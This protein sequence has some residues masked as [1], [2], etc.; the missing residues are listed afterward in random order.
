MPER[1]IV[2]ADTGSGSAFWGKDLNVVAF[3]S[4]WCQKDILEGDTNEVAGCSSPLI[5]QA[6]DFQVAAFNLSIMD[7]D[8]SPIVDIV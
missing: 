3:I 2:V 6:S 7:F 8:T 5:C 1:A 4:N